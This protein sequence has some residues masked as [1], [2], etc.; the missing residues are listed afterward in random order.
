MDKKDVC[1]L[2]GSQ[3]PYTDLIPIHERIGYIEGAGQG[4]YNAFDLD[5]EKCVSGIDER[6]KQIHLK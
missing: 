2:C 5:V 6:N 3:T 1:I 4:C